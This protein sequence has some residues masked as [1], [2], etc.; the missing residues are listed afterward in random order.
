MSEQENEVITRANLMQV[1]RELEDA[2]DEM[3]RMGGSYRMIEADMLAMSEKVDQI[4]NRYTRLKGSVK[5]TYFPVRFPATEGMTCMIC[6]RPATFYEFP[7]QDDREF[8]YKACDQHWQEHDELNR[9]RVESRKK[10]E[11]SA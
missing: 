2:R 4:M 1:S 6:N 9:S 11:P 7:I 10:E 5:K 8:T 3:N